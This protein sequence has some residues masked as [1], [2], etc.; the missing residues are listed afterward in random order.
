MMGEPIEF[1]TRRFETRIIGGSWRRLA[2]L[3]GHAMTASRSWSYSL[4]QDQFWGCGGSQK[5]VASH[6]G[7]QVTLAEGLRDENYHISVAANAEL[8]FAGLNGK[9][10]RLVGARDAEVAA[11]PDDDPRLIAVTADGS[12]LAISASGLVRWSARG[13]WRRLLVAR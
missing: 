11:M 4:E 12:P 6:G 8:A 10:H 9:L 2:T 1:E 3:P 13:G 5:L 7:R